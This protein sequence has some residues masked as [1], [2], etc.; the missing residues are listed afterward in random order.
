VDIVACGQAVPDREEGVVVADLACPGAVAVAVGRKAKLS[1]DGHTIT[2]QVQCHGSCTIAGPG[3]ISSGSAAASALFISAGGLGTVT[4]S[5]VTLHD[6]A[7]G[8]SEGAKKLILT[9]VVA[10][11]NVGSG[12][13]LTAGRVRGTNV[14]TNDNG[15]HGVF[16]DYGNIRLDQLTS[17]GNSQIGLVSQAKSG[18]RLSN[19]TL[20]GNQWTLGDGPLDLSSKGRPNVSQVTCDHSK[21]PN[22]PWGICA[23]D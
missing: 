15:G 9:N 8:I 12:I 23:G 6:S 13:F 10:S 4:V 19:S 1:L 7:N 21:G 11:N 14:T 2:G 18:P 20:T 17:T 16:V 22:G 3:D 5:D